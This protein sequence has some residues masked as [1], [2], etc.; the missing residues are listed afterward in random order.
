[1]KSLQKTEKRE[2]ETAGLTFGP[3]TGRSYQTTY[4]AHVKQAAYEEDPEENLCLHWMS[5]EEIAEQSKKDP[6]VFEPCLEHGCTHAVNLILNDTLFR[7]DCSSDIT[8]DGAGALLDSVRRGF[9]SWNAGQECADGWP[10]CRARAVLNGA[11][12]FSNVK[13]VGK[14]YMLAPEESLFSCFPEEL[15]QRIAAKKVVSDLN[16]DNGGGNCVTTYDKLWLFSKSELYGGPEA[17]GLPYR[18]TLLIRSG[19]AGFGGAYRMYSETGAEVYAWLRSI[20]P[21]AEVINRHI[22]GGG[23]ETEAGYFNL[24]ALAPGFCLP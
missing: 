23:H 19:E 16:N 6:T 22:Y 4:R 8:G 10:A 1:M 5:W 24:F 17:E 2:R 9:L 20:S 13:E 18:R 7:K 14:D 12:D 3:A 15:Q 21:W 11:D